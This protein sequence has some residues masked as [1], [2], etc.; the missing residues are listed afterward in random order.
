MS[1]ARRDWLKIGAVGFGVAVLE[2]V[3]EKPVV[4]GFNYLYNGLTT[5]G[6][7]PNLNFEVNNLGEGEVKISSSFSC[8]RPRQGTG[9]VKLSFYG[10]SDSNHFDNNK[11][12][13]ILDGKQT[14]DFTAVLIG[15]PNTDI[16]LECN[17]IMVSGKKTFVEDVMV[18]FE[19]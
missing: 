17:A 10:F 6:N 14:V 8:S 2:S 5:K 7:K 15:I 12:N 13:I 3:I 16:I 19:K 9:T 4:D 18:R 1:L 11:R